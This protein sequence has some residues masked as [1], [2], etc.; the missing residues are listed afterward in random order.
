MVLAPMKKT[1]SVVLIIMQSLSSIFSASAGLFLFNAK[2]QSISS[3]IKPS[4]PLTTTT[5][6]TVPFPTQ[7]TPN[8]IN[9]PNINNPGNSHNSDSQSPNRPAATSNPL[10]TS[11]VSPF[12]NPNQQQEQTTT[13]LDEIE[14]N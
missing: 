8:S 2:A 9:A 14:K 3:S 7:R 1:I 5:A 11:G 10:V 6:I 13:M 4:L 12:L